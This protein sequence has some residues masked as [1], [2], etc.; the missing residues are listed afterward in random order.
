M[1]P[2]EETFSPETVDEQVEQL[3]RSLYAIPSR[4]GRTAD[5]QLVQNLRRMYELEQEDARSVARVQRQLEQ[6]GWLAPERRRAS[7]PERGRRQERRRSEPLPELQA[8]TY[9][10]RAAPRQ[11]GWTFRLATIAAVLLVTTLI[12][13]LVVGLVLVHTGKGSLPGQGTATA[14]PS[15]P[16]ATGAPSGPTA[17]ATPIPLSQQSVYVASENG[18]IT[19]LNASTGRVRWSYQSMGQIRAVPNHYGEG[20][21]LSMALS[22][23]V[24]YIGSSAGV[25]AVNTRNGSMLWQDKIGGGQGAPIV[26]DGVVYVDAPTSLLALRANDG[27]VLWKQITTSAI[28]G[29]AGV[30][31]GVVYVGGD[32]SP[33][34]AFDANNGKL[35]WQNMDGGLLWGEAQGA[36]YYTT[37]GGGTECCLRA[38]N[39]RDGTQRWTFDQKHEAVPYG[40]VGNIVYTSSSDNYFY[41]LNATDGSI[42]WKSEDVHP[43]FTLWAKLFASFFYTS[44]NQGTVV[45]LNPHDGSQ[46]WMSPTFGNA[47]VSPDIENQGTLYVSY[48]ENNEA[49]GAGVAALDVGDGTMKWKARI[50]TI[51]FPTVEGVINGAVYLGTSIYGQGT[52]N[53]ISAFSTSNGSPLWQYSQAGL[54]PGS[55]ID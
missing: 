32:N 7:R 26:R 46:Q 4:Q 13:G 34:Y 9:R 24:L 25:E 12:G 10:E 47:S 37:E 15:G 36:A 14:V 30:S 39:G 33:N 17:T 3:S 41:A 29:L 31:E 43:V 1:R 22:N 27:H 35:L 48:Q 2:D 52:V 42:V 11:R 6:Q 45:A 55:L 40:F 54:L 21:G 28:Y 51:Y 44:T 5:A 19:A 16:T 38:I 23:G 20:S 53:T 49:D 50:N 18:V 8:A